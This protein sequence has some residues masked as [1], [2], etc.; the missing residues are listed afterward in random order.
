MKQLKLGIFIAVVALLSQGVAAKSKKATGE[1]IPFGKLIEMIATQSHWSED[2]LA[3]IGLT[4]LV[5]E[6]SAECSH[7]MFM[8]RM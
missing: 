6:K 4:K 8:G 2:N 5:S 3:K 1:T 7:I